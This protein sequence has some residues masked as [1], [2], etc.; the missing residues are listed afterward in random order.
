MNYGIDIHV[1]SSLQSCVHDKKNYMSYHHHGLVPEDLQGSVCIQMPCAW[2][3]VHSLIHCKKNCVEKQTAE[4]VNTKL[5][6]PSSSQK[7]YS[8]KFCVIYFKHNTSF[9]LNAY[10]IFLNYLVRSFLHFPGL[11]IEKHSIPCYTMCKVPILPHFPVKLKQSHEKGLKHT[12]IH[13]R[14][15]PSMASLSPQF[16]SPQPEN[17]CAFVSQFVVHTSHQKLSRAVVNYRMRKLTALLHWYQIDKSKTHENAVSE[18][19]PYLYINSA[20]FHN[21]RI[22]LIW[23]PTIWHILQDEGTAMKLSHRNI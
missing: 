9:R 14:A 2:T 6:V 5:N 1:V 8:K 21:A 16:T 4:N 19:L 18:S 13:T 23:F 22:I 11:N 15:M 10:K 12:H 7:E 3:T 17:W 20:L